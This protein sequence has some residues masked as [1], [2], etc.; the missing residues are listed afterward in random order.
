MLRCLV[1]T[2]LQYKKK[3]RISEQCKQR[4][5]LLL[6]ANRLLMLLTRTDVTVSVLFGHRG[7]PSLN[8]VFQCTNMT[9]NDP[10]SGSGDPAGWDTQ[11]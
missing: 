1:V 11:R 4:N 6:K 5:I 10:M 8:Y 7:Q 9:V 3:N 2:S